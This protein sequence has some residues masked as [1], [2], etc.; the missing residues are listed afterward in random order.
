MIR[1]TLDN[2]C[3]FWLPPS[4]RSLVERMTVST[5]RKT[6]HHSHMIWQTLRCPQVDLRFVCTAIEPLASKREVM[7][8]SQKLR[9]MRLLSPRSWF[10]DACSA[11]RKHTRLGGWRIHYGSTQINLRWFFFKNDH[12]LPLLSLVVWPDGSNFSKLSLLSRLLL[13]SSGLTFVQCQKF[14]FCGGHDWPSLT[15]WLHAILTHNV[16]RRSSSS[17]T[18][19]SIPQPPVCC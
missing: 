10:C 7:L 19:M 5:T 9:I 17:H 8:R 4:P 18:R 16:T 11:W 3:L 1:Q 12:K 13:M 15:A 14:P 2:L 6:A